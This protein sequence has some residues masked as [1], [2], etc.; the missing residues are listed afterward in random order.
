MRL[1][2]HCIQ[3]LVTGKERVPRVPRQRQHPNEHELTLPLAEHTRREGWVFS[4]SHNVK[5]P[6]C[7]K[8]FL[9][10]T[11]GSRWTQE[12]SCAH[13]GGEGRGDG[14]RG[15]W[16]RTPVTADV[17]HGHRRP[18]VRTASI[19]CAESEM[20]ST[21]RL[22]SRPLL[23]PNASPGDSALSLGGDLKKRRSARQRQ[24]PAD[25]CKR[26][27]TRHSA[28]LPLQRDAGPSRWQHGDACL[29]GG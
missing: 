8:E 1:G 17:S 20:E 29:Q 15:T 9:L 26:F 16:T 12:C 10:R 19:C 11:E 28:R 27:P 13:R 25:H 3:H 24:T 22:C 18:P 2:N 6:F 14:R 5:T 23:S 21:N 7:V 4:N